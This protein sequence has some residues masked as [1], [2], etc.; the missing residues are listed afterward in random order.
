M[1]AEHV[2]MVVLHN[3]RGITLVINVF[4]GQIWLFEA[5]AINVNAS[6][7]DAD[8]VSGQAYD[9][10]DIGLA[11]IQGIPENNDVATLDRLKAV[12]EFVDEDALVILETRH[13]AGAFYLDRLVE[14]ND[15][16]KGQQNRQNQVAQPEARL[17]ELADQPE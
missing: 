16:D 2:V 8:A 3:G 12:H 6:I 1:I 5:P 7:A 11:R 15:D 4:R 14:K 13:H 10:F 17:E 9:A